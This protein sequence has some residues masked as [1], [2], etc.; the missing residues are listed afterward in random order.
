MNGTSTNRIGLLT[1]GSRAQGAPGDYADQS[2]RR[3]PTVR[4]GIYPREKIA[5]NLGCTLPFYTIC[6]QAPDAL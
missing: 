4:R 5:K 3:L 2:L 1:V 6:K